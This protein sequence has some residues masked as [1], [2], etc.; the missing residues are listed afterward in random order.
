MIMAKNLDLTGKICWITGA[1]GG[2]GTPAVQMFAEAGAK[3]I[4]IHYRSNKKKA[5]T[6]AGAAEQ[7]GAETLLL[8][9]SISEANNTAEMAEKIHEKWGRIDSLVCFATYPFNRDNWFRKFEDLSLAQWMGPLEIDLLGS[10][11]CARAVLPYMRDNDGGS[12]V[13][14]SSTPAFTGDTVGLSYLVAKAG[15]LGLTRGLART[16]GDDNIR[17][18]AIAPGAID[19]PPMKSLTEEE[20]QELVDETVLKRLGKPEEIANA[21]L[22]L[23]SNASSYISGNIMVVDGGYHMR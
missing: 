16:L 11:Y 3:G 22:F 1:T 19:T 23:S 5:E 8:G 2:I 13:F 7:E 18:N 21:A 12:I 15:V 20:R 4:G 9:G 17:V 14:I 10:M 6:I